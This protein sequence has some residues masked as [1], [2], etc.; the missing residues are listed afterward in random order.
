MLSAIGACPRRQLK[1]EDYSVAVRDCDVR[2]ALHGTLLRDHA[3]AQD[4]TLFVDELGLCGEVRV[5]VAVIN[6]AMTGFEIKSERDTL[7]RLPK[8]VEFYSRVLDYAEI[9][10]AKNHLAEARRIVP[11]W[12]GVRVARLDADGGVQIKPV[13]RARRN[14]HIDPLSLAQLLWREEALAEL[15]AR[16]ADRGV[17]SKPRSAVWERLVQTV[18]THE[19]QSMVRSRLKARTTWR[20]A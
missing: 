10:V 16:G 18:D 9:V 3:E 14:R 2:R 13:R 5:D 1:S 6:G 15:A 20:V 7:R 17:R 4:D 11:S 8:Q 19:L 12:W